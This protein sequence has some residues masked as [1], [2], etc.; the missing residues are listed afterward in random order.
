VVVIAA[1]THSNHD[2]GIN[3]D[4]AVLL[5]SPPSSRRA[6]SFERLPRSG[7]PSN[8]PTV[9]KRRRGRSPSGCPASCRSASKAAE[10]RSSGTASSRRCASARGS[11]G[12]RLP[13]L[14]MLLSLGDRAP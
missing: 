12:S 10:T 2:A 4:H 7:S 8:T 13:S 14:V 6:I 9:R 5:D 11:A 3:K 1:V